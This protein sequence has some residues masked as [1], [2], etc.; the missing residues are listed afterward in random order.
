MDVEELKKR[1]AEEDLTLIKLIQEYENASVY[2][3]RR[4]DRA[5]IK[6]AVQGD[7]VIIAPT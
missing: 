5:E 7:L 6:V 4:K 1:F 3:C 2:L